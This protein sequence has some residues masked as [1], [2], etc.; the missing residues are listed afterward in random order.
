MVCESKTCVHVGSNVSI[1]NALDGHVIE[2][3][4][5]VY[6]ENLLKDVMWCL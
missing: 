3:I 2:H 6:C 1:I 4:L 5:K